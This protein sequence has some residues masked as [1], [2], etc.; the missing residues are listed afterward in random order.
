RWLA[1]ALEQT[2]GAVSL[3]RGHALLAAAEL[4]SAISDFEYGLQCARQAQDLFQQ[5][6]DQ[7]REID[8]GLVYCDLA[9]YAGKLAH[10]QTQIEEALQMAEHMS[11]MAGMA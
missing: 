10:L 1:R 9:R 5:L 11:H 2:E 8:A 3:Q 7:R 4:S 6:G